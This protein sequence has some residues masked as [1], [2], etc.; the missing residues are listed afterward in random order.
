MQEKQDFFIRAGQVEDE[1]DLL[2]ELNELEAEM[3]E[4]ELAQLEIGAGAIGN[5]EK[6]RPQPA[7]GNRVVNEEDELRAL[8]QMMAWFRSA[9]L[10]RS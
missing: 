8:E 7:V 3:A 9:F 10:A 6:V 1:D 4:D 5:G 2:D